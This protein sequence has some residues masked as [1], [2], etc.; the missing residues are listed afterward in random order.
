MLTYSADETKEFA[1]ELVQTFK[2]GIVLALKGDLGSGK[3]TFV[4]GLAEGLGLEQ[5]IT[6]PTFILLREYPLPELNPKGLDIQTLY[7]LDFYRLENK[8]LEDELF[9]LG[10]PEVFLNP[11]G[12]SVVEWA[13]KYPSIFPKNT[14]WIYFENKGDNVREI[15]IN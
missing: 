2:G 9:N 10:L 12:L 3:T 13:D 5:S 1:K 4:Q 15:K 6:S 8:G 11:K 14:M 7:H